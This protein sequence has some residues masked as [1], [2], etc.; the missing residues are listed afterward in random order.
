MDL[1][2]IKLK[3]NIYT[4]VT[5]RAN[6]I[7]MEKLEWVWPDRIPAG[8]ICPYTGKP[9]CGKSLAILDLVARVTTGK[10]C[11]DAKN[12][13]GLRDVVLAATEDDL[14][15]TLVPRLVACDADLSRIHIVKRVTVEG[16]KNSHRMLQLKEGAQLIRRMLRDHPDVALIALDPISG[17]FGDVDPNKD[18]E[19]RPVLESVQAALE[20]SKTALV[21][22]IHQNKRGDTDAL[23]KVLGG[24]AVVGVSRAVWG[25]SRDSE[26]KNLCYMTLVKG[27]LS[28]KRSGMKY[29]IDGKDIPLGNGENTNA[30]YTSWQEETD[31]DADQVLNKERESAKSGGNNPKLM[32][33]TVIIKDALKNGPVA[34]TEMYKNRD[35]EGI[36]DRTFKKAYYDVGVQANNQGDKWY[37]RIPGCETPI[38]AEDEKAIADQKAYRESL[39]NPTLSS[40]I[41]VDEVM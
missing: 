28:K 9:S 12:P 7:Q 8:K 14:G 15:T 33:A 36:D 4:L 35:A 39:E 21:G 11:P 38:S 40:T 5:Q 1:I 19:I 17:F 6:T 18:K 2:L 22:I 30:A 41:D 34:A 26:D 37:W 16:K 31:M 24:S 3:E 25:F 20:Q 23:G 32:I 10:D 13:S 29:K 27:N